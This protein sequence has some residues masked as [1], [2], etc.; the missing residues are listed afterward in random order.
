MTIC[1]TAAERQGIPV[2]HLGILRHNIRNHPVLIGFDNPRHNQKQRPEKNKQIHHKHSENRIQIRSAFKSI[3]Q[4]SDSAILT[5]LSAFHKIPAGSYIN[6]IS[7]KYRIQRTYC[8]RKQH[9]H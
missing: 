4:L 6:H 3:K 1:H 9:P 5:E 7:Y 2:I 8:K